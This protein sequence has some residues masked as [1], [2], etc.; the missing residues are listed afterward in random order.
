MLERNVNLEGASVLVTGAA[1]FVGY[2]LVLELL[3]TVPGVKIVGLDN[4][5]YVFL[6]PPSFSLRRKSQKKATH[7]GSLSEV[8][9]P[10]RSLLI[11]A[12]ENTALTL[13]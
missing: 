4:M 11:P 5:N 10:I 1:G 8:I 6:F 12:S 3:E 2:H 13:L 7:P 9:L